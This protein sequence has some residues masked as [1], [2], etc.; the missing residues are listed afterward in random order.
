MTIEEVVFDLLSTAQGVR[1]LVGLRIYPVQTEESAEFPFVIYQEAENVPALTHDGAGD[2][3]RHS[4]DIDVWAL[5]YPEAKRLARAVRKA[6]HGFRGRRRG[7]FV[8][9]IFLRSEADQHEL[10][11][12]AEERGAFGVTMNFELWFRPVETGVTHGG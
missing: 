10:P 9:G 3:D 12:T 6:L 8:Q 7:C 5:D 1:S 2:S 11:Q 4:M